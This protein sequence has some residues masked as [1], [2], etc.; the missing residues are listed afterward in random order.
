MRRIYIDNLKGGEVLAQPI[1][2]RD[3][4]IFLSK[5]IHIKESYIPKIRGI[6]IDYLY[7]EDNISEGIE[8]EDFIHER[9]RNKC[10]T[11]VR[12]VIEKYALTGTAKIDDIAD[13]A[14]N[15]VDDILSG[16]DIVVNLSDIRR[17]DEW[18]YAH[19]VNVCSLS[20]LTALNMGMNS[21]KAKDVA[22]GA[23]IHDLGIAMVPKQI[24][25]KTEALTQEEE[26]QYENHVV[27]GYEAVKNEHWL[28]AISKVIILTHHER[29]D[30]SGYPFGWTGDKLHESAKIVAVCDVFDT[31]THKKP[32]REAYKIYEVIE[33][34]NATKG[35]LFDK[36]VVEAFVNFIAIY[37]SGTGV[38]LNTD[39]RAIV[40]KQN[41]GM[42]MR[43]VIRLIIDKSGEKIS[44]SPDLDLL[45]EKTL[46]ITGTFEF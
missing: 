41:K 4:R 21:G 24:I 45:K 46:F 37:P 12:Q 7:I 14:Q 16:K 1:Y 5:G 35:I 17:E 30:G 25:E 33:Y 38:I 13:V 26:K 8:V 20:V 42:P 22:I 43:P 29:I 15:I 44:K 3:D 27:H 34:L 9:T 18:V 36:D 28:S 32:N 40:V 31:M 23:M 2:T 39:E 19:C 11:E 10:K 6:G